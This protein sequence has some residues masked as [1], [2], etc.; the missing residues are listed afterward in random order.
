MIKLYCFPRSGNSREVKIVLAEKGLAFEPINIHADKSVTESPDFL[1]ASP[2]KTVPALI[3]GDIYMSEA[4]LINEY[5]EDKYPQ[6]SILP[7]DKN[8][9]A[10]IRAWVA[11]Y[12]KRLCLKIGLLLIECLLK[13]KELQKEET[14]ARLRNEIS[15]ALKDADAFLGSKEYFFGNYSLADVSLTPHLAALG[16]V[17]MELGEDLTGLKHW[18]ERVKSRPSF[19]MTQQ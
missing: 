13:A 17:G 18:L 15:A 7:K 8:E 14:K 1:K 5:L 2:K 19:Q 9:R 6:N 16:R 10:K 11:D 4:Y 12:D 3:D